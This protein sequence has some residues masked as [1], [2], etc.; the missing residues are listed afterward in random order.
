MASHGPC[1][2][3]LRVRYYGYYSNVFEGKR[4]RRGSNELMPLMFDTPF[5]ESGSKGAGHYANAISP[6]Y[7]VPVFPLTHRED[8]AIVFGQTGRFFQERRTAEG[9]SSL[10][11]PYV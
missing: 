4:K 2:G 5:P 8:P 1:M 3:E 11:V 10:P 6:G 9:L 7:V